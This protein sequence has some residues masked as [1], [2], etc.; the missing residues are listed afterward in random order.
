M[1]KLAKKLVRIA[2]WMRVRRRPSIA[3]D[4]EPELIRRG[5]LPRRLVLPILAALL[6][7]YPV[8]MI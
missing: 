3:E 6:L 2:G 1:K 4:A 8:G 7:Y 5:R